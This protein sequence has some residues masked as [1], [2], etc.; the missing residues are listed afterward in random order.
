MLVSGSQQFVIEQV[1]ASEPHDM[2]YFW[3]THQGAEIDLIIQRDAELYG[4]ECKRT[5]APKMTPSISH[6]LNDLNLKR[7][8]VIYPGPKRYSLADRVEAVPLAFLG[9]GNSLFD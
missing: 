8:A 9:S 3:S 1:L 5:D 6:A 4:I 7:V 2:A